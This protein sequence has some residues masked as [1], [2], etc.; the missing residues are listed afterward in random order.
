MIKFII[1]F[2]FSLT[3]LSACSLQPT[4]NFQSEIG[5]STEPTIA[6]DSTSYSNAHVCEQSDSCMVVVSCEENPDAETCYSAP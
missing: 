6:R 5:S 2:G 1:L 4:R 3:I